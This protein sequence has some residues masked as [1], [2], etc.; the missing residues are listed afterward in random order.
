MPV[1][2]I[3]L[4]PNPSQPGS[5]ALPLKAITFIDNSTLQGIIPANGPIGT[6][7]IIVINPNDEI[8]ILTKGITITTNE[9]PI[10][11]A[12]VPGYLATNG[13]TAVTI[14]GRNFD[15]NS[16]SLTLYCQDWNNSNSKLTLTTT[17]VQ[18]N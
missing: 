7:D 3:F 15:T 2:R 10:V 1:P 5:F 11:T 13:P 14:Y 16:V 4:N 17:S 8:G 18:G 12:I 9:P 6:Y